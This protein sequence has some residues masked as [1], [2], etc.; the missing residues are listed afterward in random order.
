LTEDDFAGSLEFSRTVKFF[1]KQQL[2]WGRGAI[3]LTPWLQPGEKPTGI[4]QEPFLTVLLS[5]A[6]RE[7]VKTVQGIIV[8]LDHGAEATVLIRSLRVP[9]ADSVSF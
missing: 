5:G 9:Q 6:S 2:A 4:D 3:S 1:G 8:E 7:T